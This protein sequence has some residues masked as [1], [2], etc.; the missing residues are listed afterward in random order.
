MKYHIPQILVIAI[1][2]SPIENTHVN[3]LFIIQLLP[4][5]LLALDDCFLAVGCLLEPSRLYFLGLTPG[6]CNLC[7]RILSNKCLFRVI[8]TGHLS[9]TLCKYLLF[10]IFAENSH[11]FCVLAESGDVDRR[12]SEYG[13]EGPSAVV[14]QELDQLL[15][16]LEGGPVERRHSQ[17]RRHEVDISA[18]L[19]ENRGAL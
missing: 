1:E 19:D 18:P 3:C 7:I 12:V 2:G 8:T 6:G 13:F 17:F 9:L 14:N 15:V 4:L 5:V 10:E 11:N 16:I